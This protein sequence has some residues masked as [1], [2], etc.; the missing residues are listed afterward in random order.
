MATHG[1][2]V[3]QMIMTV[4]IPS[5]FVEFC[6]AT[7]ICT[8]SYLKASS[9]IPERKQ[10]HMFGTAG[11]LMLFQQQFMQSLDIGLKLHRQLLQGTLES[12]KALGRTSHRHLSYRYM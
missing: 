5:S 1:F 4:Q 3:F 2:E 12:R 8:M 10:I 7:T 9:I 11:Q 6:R